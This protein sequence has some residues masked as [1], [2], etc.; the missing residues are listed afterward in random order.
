MSSTSPAPDAIV[1]VELV[2]DLS[3]E[4]DTEPLI[5]VVTSTSGP[6]GPPGPEGPPGDT[7]PP[8]PPGADGATGPA[9]AQ[10]PKGD[11]GATGAQ[12]PAGATGAQ[13]PPGVPGDTVAAAANR[14]IANMLAAGDTQPAWR[15][16]G[17]GKMEWGAGGS[18]APD[19]SLYRTSAGY[20]ALGS[21]T[22]R[23]RFIVFGG[24]ATD[25][26]YGTRVGAESV[27]RFGIR[28][29]GLLSWGD[30][31]ASD[32]LL[33]RVG[34]GELALGNNLTPGLL[35]IWGSV[36]AS[37]ILRGFVT[38]E[39]QPRLVLRASG[40]LDFG[41][42]SA[43]ADTTLAR[44]AAGE[45]SI[46]TS[47]QAGLLRLNAATTNAV[48]LRSFVTGNAQPHFTIRSDGPLQWSDGTN[49]A[50]TVLQRS[51]ADRLNTPDL[52][53][54]TTMGLATKVKA[55]APVDADWA[56]APPDG[57]IVADSTGS[58]LW[59]RVAGAWKGVAIA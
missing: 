46:G 40:E 21:S 12:G 23:G 30:G 39:A 48:I 22:Q 10:G 31:T 3:V 13:G 47:S 24:V 35:R 2:G 32:I 58:K 52:F 51:G 43:V 14:V 53:V 5:Q 17:D 27:D 54:A 44:V 9:G 50:D 8:G 18:S 4:V 19:T 56:V 37:I 25:A 29:D 59:V 6:P 34:A 20:L 11:T 26:A 57:T 36:A 45:L 15:V 38:G 55:G 42:G 33:G 16:L 28:A 49:P 41:P 1:G 7:G